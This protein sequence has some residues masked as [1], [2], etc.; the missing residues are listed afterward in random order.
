MGL[1]SL[2]GCL[3]RG[4]F[5]SSSFVR[6]GIFKQIWILDL[7]PGFDTQFWNQFQLELIPLGR[8]YILSSSRNRVGNRVARLT[9]EK[10]MP[11]LKIN[12]LWSMGNPI[13]NPILRIN[14]IVQI[15][16]KIPLRF[17]ESFLKFKFVS[18]YPLR[19]NPR[20]YQHFVAS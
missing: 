9:E 18:K 10:S 12:I 11:C 19:S 3:D 2:L 1:V 20:G 13:P 5:L 15:C 4:V 8:G 16:L 6:G 14:S 17:P 7:I